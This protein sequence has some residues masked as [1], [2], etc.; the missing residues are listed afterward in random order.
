[1]AKAYESLHQPLSM[2]GKVAWLLTTPLQLLV[3]RHTCRTRVVI[4]KRKSQGHNVLLVKQWFSDG[5][6]SLPGGGIKRS[7]TTKPAAAREIREELGLRLDV[8]KLT[9]M[10]NIGHERT[11]SYCAHPLMVIVKSNAKI[12]MREFEISEYAWFSLDQLPVDI[13]PVSEKIIKSVKRRMVSI[14][15]SKKPKKKR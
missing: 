1:M 6:W 2:I 10:H 13:S 14:K 15:T 3:L 8:K 5:K 12:N 9:Q 4:L 11:G 7:E